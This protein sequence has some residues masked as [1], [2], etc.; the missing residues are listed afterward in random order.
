MKLIEIVLCTQRDTKYAYSVGL[1]ERNCNI[2]LN[3]IFYV[4]FVRV[5]SK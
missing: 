3:S 5:L 2:N 1:I 4:Q